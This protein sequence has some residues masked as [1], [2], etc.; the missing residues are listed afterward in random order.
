MGAV[1]EVIAFDPEF[2]DAVKDRLQADAAAIGRSLMEVRD[3]GYDLEI[4]DADGRTT[5]HGYLHEHALDRDYVAFFN[6]HNALM[7]AGIV[8]ALAYVSEDE[9]IAAYLYDELLG[10][11]AL[12]R[13]ASEAMVIDFGVGTNYSNYNMAFSAA[14]L[15]DRYL[16]GAAMREDLR[17]TA[18][19]LYSPEGSVRPVDEVGQSFFDFVYAAIVADA[20]AFGETTGVLDADAVERGRATLHAFPTPPNWDLPVENCDAAEIA[21]QTC[22]LDDGTPVGLIVSGAWNDTLVADEIVPIEIRAPSNYVW[23]S[24][25]FDVNGGSDGSNLPSSSDFR[26]AYWIGRWT[27]R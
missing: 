16:E 18:E 21:A 9:E 6:G 1:W 13:I 11:R 23:R 8:A 20:S 3:S 15:A 19:V 25:P 2:D 24:N 27:R 17:A 10:E 22:Q 14:W 12:L 4:L 26:I 7:A 5:Y